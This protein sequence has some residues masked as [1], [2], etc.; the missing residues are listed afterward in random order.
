MKD[1]PASVACIIAGGDIPADSLV[2]KLARSADLVVCAD[3]G[4]RHASRLGIRPDV[5]LGDLDSLTP[6]GRRRF[7]RVIIRRFPDQESTDLE[8]AIRYCVSLKIAGAVIAGAAG[9][10][11]DHSTSA[12][13]CFRKF[14]RKIRLMLVDRAGSL[15]LLGPDEKIPMKRGETFSLIPLDRCRGVR[16]DGARYPLCGETL[17]LGVREGISN[18]ATGVS[19]R[20]RHSG[21]TLL[22]YRLRPPVHPRRAVGGRPG[23]PRRNR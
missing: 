5:I 13:G 15:T 17:Q 12:L 20:V 23:K 21:G 1:I 3:G 9:D 18:A 2:V 14:G 6:A 16:L 10:R 7:H 11:L 8:K 19:V 22:L 4:A